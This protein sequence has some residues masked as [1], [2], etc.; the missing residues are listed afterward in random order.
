VFFKL[1]VL[2]HQCLNG[3][4]PLH[5]HRTCRTTASRSPVLSLG[6]ICFL[7]TVNYLQYLATVST[8]TAA[9]PFQLLAP[10]SGTLSG[11][12]P[13]P[14]HQCRV[15]QTFAKN[16]FVCWILVRCSWRLLCYIKLLTCTYLLTELL[17]TSLLSSL[18]TS[19]ITTF[20]SSCHCGVH[21]MFCLSMP[22]LLCLS[23]SSDHTCELCQNKDNDLN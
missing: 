6:G 9:V 4:A 12:Y 15:F 3:H 5:R 10:Q 18:T 20:S 1:A 23:V 21:W 8:L 2:V 11:F 7:P 14:D 13:G 16:V 22:S 19:A 17:F